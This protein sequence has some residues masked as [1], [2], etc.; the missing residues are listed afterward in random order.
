MEKLFVRA[1]SPRD[2]MPTILPFMVTGRRRS[3]C[4]DM[5]SKAS[6]TSAEASTVTALL[7]MTSFTAIFCG[8]MP[9]AARRAM[10]LSV[11]MPLTFLSFHTGIEA[12]P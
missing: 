2:T 8:L 6:D 12:M 5:S 3:L 1:M 11:I 7:L 4:S 10:S 9:L